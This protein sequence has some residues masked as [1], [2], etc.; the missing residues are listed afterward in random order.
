MRGHRGRA[1]TA[2]ALAVLLVLTG[3][4]S[5]R[6]AA[7]SG[8]AASS[9]EDLRY[10]AA[11]VPGPEVT[12]QPDV[13]LVGGGGR[14]VRSVT[15]DGLTWRLDRHA[16][17]ADDLAPGKVMFVTGRGVGRVLD[18]AADGDDLLVTIGPVDITEVIRDGTFEKRGLTLD[19][20]VIYPAGEPSWAEDSP[21][22][23]STYGRSR[24][25][26]Q[27]PARAS[28]D[29]PVQ[30][31]PERG[32]TANTRAHGYQVWSTC[33]TDGVGAH[34]TYD[35]GGVRLVGTVT[36]TFNR[37]NAAFHLAI[38][39]GRVNRAELEIGG[40]FGIKVEFEGGIRDGQNHKKSFP[41]AADISFPI[42][43]LVGIP[44]SFTISQTLSV[45]TAFG[46]KV[47]T[48]KGAGEFA[49]AGSLG[50]G[51]ANG[52]VGPRIAK[53]FQRKSSLIN[54]L[55]GVPVGVMGLVIRHGVRFTV[56]ISAF[57][58]KAGIYFEL[59]TSYGSTLGS[60]LGA[61]LAE[62]RGVAIGVQAVFGIG[63]RIL[64]PVVEVINKFLSLLKP[65]S[66]PAIKPIGAESGPRWSADVYR[67][68]EVIPDVAVC[69]HP[70]R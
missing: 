14:S 33:C 21:P 11:P 46:A 44:I 69:G 56:G 29:Q 13:V 34:F 49:L 67:N 6:P 61:A 19:D 15:A 62:C 30:P 5:L 50:F 60:A 41:I 31:G 38:G 37:P 35:D 68:E 51:Y 63:Y 25:M 17:N 59:T 23:P 57:L 40:G 9:G 55:T 70:P 65:S 53:N 58:F 4:G 1:L 48:V 18:L 39:A 47:G 12:L 45:A 16:R 8:D 22:P 36:L 20:P 64:E 54:S 43:Q 52:T 7:R 26:R 28:A 32:G 27:L 42:G 66:A 3:C 2:V 10:G 24:P